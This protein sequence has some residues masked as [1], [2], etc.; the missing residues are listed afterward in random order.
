MATAAQMMSMVRLQRD[1]ER[2]QIVLGDLDA[3]NGRNRSHHYTLELADRFRL[4][5]I[6]LGFNPETGVLRNQAGYGPAL[7]NMYLLGRYAADRD[8]DAAEEDNHAYYA[9]QGIV[10]ATMSFRRKLSL[11]LMTADFITLGQGYD[12]VLIQ[13]GIDEHKYVRFAQQI[14][15]RLNEEAPLRHEFALTALYT[16]LNRGFGG[17]PKFSKSIPASAIGVETP[18]DEIRRLVISDDAQDPEAS[19][20]YQLMCQ[21]SYCS[22]EDLLKL[23]RA[24]ASGSSSWD[25][26][27]RRFIRFLVHVKE[28]WPT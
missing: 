4:F 2:C 3:Y 13:L 5:A 26:E 16:R 14:A 24:C 10:D 28:Q 27:R 7:L 17:H 9:A 11:A 12:A 6:R 22:H 23:Y 21:M 20:V 18:N 15:A 1:G 19:P 8:F 25:A